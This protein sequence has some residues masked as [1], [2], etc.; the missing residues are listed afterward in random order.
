MERVSPALF[1][2]EIV[3]LPLSERRH[4]LPIARDIAIAE[5][6]RPEE[7]KRGSAIA[8]GAAAL[9]GAA[10]ATALLYPRVTRYTRW[11]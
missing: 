7:Q 10:V 4:P 6:M 9:L 1:D 11:W 2:T 5:S 3:R 8:L